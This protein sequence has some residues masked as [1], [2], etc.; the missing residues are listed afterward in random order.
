VAPED[1]AKSKSLRVALIA[2]SRTVCEYSIFLQRLLVGLADESVPV[3]LVCPAIQ[4]A[5]CSFTGTAEVIS[6]PVLNLPLMGPLNMR[7]LVE[8][9]GRFKPTVLHCLCE[10]QASLTA[11]LARRLDLPYILTVNSLQK[12]RSSISVSPSHC[13]GIL[14]PAKSIADN[15]AELFPDYAGLIEQINVGTFA[16]EGGGCFSRPSRLATLV[17][18]HSSGDVDELENVFSV[19]RHLILDGY[20]FLMVAM[21]GR[22]ERQ[23]WKM[24]VALDLLPVVTIVPRLMPWHLVATAGDIFIRPRPT[25]T[26]DP[27]LLEAMGIGTAVAACRGGVDDLILENRTAVVFNPDDELNIMRT[28]QRLLDRREFACQLARSARQ[29]IRENYTVSGMIAAIFEEYGKVQA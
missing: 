19:V 2:S 25:S 15:L 1:V 13:V 6:H 7:L 3:A 18:A 21:V 9:L 10:S 23:L 22:Q 17:M 29:Y 26:F 4:S 16:A 20:E 14:T 12:R 8:A 11:Q 27:L 5:A 24:L 28:L